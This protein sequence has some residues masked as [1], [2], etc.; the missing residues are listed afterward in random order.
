MANPVTLQNLLPPITSDDVEALLL[1]ALQGIG[2]VQQLGQGAGQVV[3]TGSPLSNYDA[4]IIMQG[5]GAPGTATF[6]YS[7][8][9]AATT[10]GPFT[11]PSNG[12]YPISGSGLTLTFSGT[13]VTGDEYLFQTVF[14]PFQA[15]DFQSGSAA[16][17][18]LKSEAATEANLAGSAIPNIAAG[19]FVDYASSASAPQDWLTLLSQQVYN[20]SR[21]DPSVLTG[22]IQLVMAATG[23]TQTFSAGQ[24]IVAN[25]LGSG[26]NVFQYVNSS[27]FTITASQTLVVPV[28]AV[29]P[30][31]AYNLANGTITSII[32]PRPGMTCSNPAPGT[33]AV[34]AS[35]GATG[36]ITVSGAPNG[37]YAVIIRVLTTGGRGVATIQISLD[38]GAD[39]AAPFT[40]PSSGPY[41]IPTLNGLA[42]TGLSL[43]FT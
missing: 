33:S 39:F 42:L 34:T 29:A 8:D 12:Q 13:F 31:S 27:G 6:T 28:T 21:F 4:I 23:S 9:G 14:P 43:D 26:N 18:F 40:I 7:L 11:V 19:G 22:V 38:G 35:A 5:G 25:S 20:N 17:T 37:N 15:T 16:L 41:A 3:I 1:Q 24:L 32:T 36:T 10:A 30:G 2:P